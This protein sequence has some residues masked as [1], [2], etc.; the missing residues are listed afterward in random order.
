MCVR[1]R[2]SG[3]INLALNIS[4]HNRVHTHPPL[5]RVCYPPCHVPKFCRVHCTYE[6]ASLFSTTLTR[7]N[8]ITHHPLLPPRP[9]IAYAVIMME[10][11]NDIHFLLPIMVAIMC[12]KLVADSSTHSLYHA[13]IELKCI[14]F[15]DHLPSGPGGVS[16][17]LSAASDIMANPVETLPVI[18]SVRKLAQVL[19]NGQHH[20]FPVVSLPPGDAANHAGATR[21]GCF[22]GL[23]LREHLRLIL[24][25][26]DLFRP[27]GAHHRAGS[28][29]DVEEGDGIGAF[30][31]LE[32][33]VIGRLEE[34]S[35]GARPAVRARTETDATRREAYAHQGARDSPIWESQLA[36][37]DSPEYD[38]VQVNLMPYANTSAFTVTASMSLERT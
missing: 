25:H 31:T 37:L 32:Y 8:Y 13:L 23:I 20:A 2:V 16:L 18:C 34:P 35:L 9:P 5:P 21:E 36:K 11:T 19:R 10:I 27:T 26:E 17:E 24:T 15:L 1:Y 14:P 33:E 6:A 28:G 7:K 30:P 22:L 12:A 4:A 29:A 3:A 38:G